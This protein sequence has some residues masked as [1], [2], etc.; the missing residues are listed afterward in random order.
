M[1]TAPAPKTGEHN[2]AVCL[3]FKCRQTR[4]QLRRCGHYA[5]EP[6]WP[7]KAHPHLEAE[8]RELF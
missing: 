3:C 4:S 7:K 2:E 5:P 8:L 6:Y 1:V